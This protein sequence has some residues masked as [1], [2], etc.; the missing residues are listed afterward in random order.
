MFSSRLLFLK[1]KSFDLI[2]ITERI[3]ACQDPTE[4]PASDARRRKAGAAAAHSGRSSPLPAGLP[5]LMGLRGP[6]IAW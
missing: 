2:A 5:R 1:M 3:E 4:F 6:S